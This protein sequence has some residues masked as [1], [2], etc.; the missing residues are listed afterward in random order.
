M[1]HCGPV[2]NSSWT[3]NDC[4]QDA[5]H[6]ISDLDAIEQGIQAGIQ[7]VLQVRVLFPF[8][9]FELLQIFS[10]ENYCYT[11]YTFIKCYSRLRWL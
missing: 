4:Y 6:K 10:E 2:Q 8:C 11:F 9:F 3:R 7:A 5:L 1:N